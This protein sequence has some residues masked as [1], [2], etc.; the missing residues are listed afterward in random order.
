MVLMR[1]TEFVFDGRINFIVV[2]PDYGP[3]RSETCRSVVIYVYYCDCMKVVHCH[4]I[5]KNRVIMQGMENIEFVIAE[6]EKKIYQFKQQLI[7]SLMMDQ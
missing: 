2:L 4:L 3:V 5:V 7:Y 6:H 1:I